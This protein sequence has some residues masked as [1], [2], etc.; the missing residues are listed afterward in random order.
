MTGREG[1]LHA[2]VVLGAKVGADGGPS[3][4][5][6]R[7]VALGVRLFASGRAPLVV[8][9]GGPTRAPWLSEAAVAATA[10]RA[11]GLPQRA[12]VLEE[13]SRSTEENARFVAEL[14]GSSAKIAIVTDDFHLARARWKFEPHFAHVEGEAVRSPL[15]DRL[16][17]GVREL[18]LLAIH[19]ATLLLSSD[20]SRQPPRPAAFEQGRSAAPLERPARSSEP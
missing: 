1:Q 5:L 20:R 17:G 13:H 10:A 15:V 19:A 3:A 14:L 2:I 9:S 7:R 4:A 6:A 12:I 18:P 8:F 16:R 11:L